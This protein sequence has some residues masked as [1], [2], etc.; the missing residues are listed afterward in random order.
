MDQI[1][2][3]VQDNMILKVILVL[4]AIYFF[5]QFFY[6]EQLENVESELVAILSEAEPVVEAEPAVEEERVVEAAVDVQSI[7][8]ESIDQAV[9]GN[10]QLTS[11]DLLPKY[12]DANDFSKQNPV[13]KLLQEQNFLTSSYHI[14]IDTVGTAKK[15]QYF[16]IRSSPPIPKDNSLSPWNNSSY[17]IPAGS[18][19]R[20]LEGF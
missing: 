12:D 6:R 13:S 3:T 15:M 7:D 20:H 8:Q 9:A 10:Q 5:M 17:E 18:G 19:R 1:I 16:D 4:V 14:G 11:I 2:K